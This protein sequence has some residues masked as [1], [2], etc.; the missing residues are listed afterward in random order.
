[1]YG[2][3][4]GII[5]DETERRITECID[6]HRE[7]L[8]D[9]ARDLM[10]H[11][12][13][14]F[15]EIRTASR[16]SAFFA[17]LGLE[18]E[19]GLARTGVRGRMRNCRPGPC[20]TILG[21]M[22]AIG[23]RSHPLADPVNG[24]AHACGHHAQ[25]AAMAGAALA[26]TD[27][28]VRETLDGRVE[29]L[30]VPAEEYVDADRRK[31]LA[32]EGVGFPAS[33]KSEMIRT[34]VFDDT[35]LCMTTHVHMIPVKEDFL[36]GNPTCNG[37]AA[38]RVTIRGKA[39]HAAIDPLDG[40]NALS[41]AGSALSMMGMMRETFP[42]KDHIRLHNLIRKAGDVINSVPDEAILETKV[43][44]ASLEAI[45]RVQ[46]QVSRAYDGAA[47]AFGGRVF[48]E[49]LQGYMPI[50]YREADLAL[51]EAA[52]LLGRSFRKAAPWDFND[53]CT[54]VG[55]LTH[56]FPV[57]NFTF[58]GFAGKLHGEDFQIVDEEKA[59]L[60]PAKLLALTAY[61]LLRDHAD[62]ARIICGEYKP[63]FDKE[64]YCAYIREN[65]YDK[66]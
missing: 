19:E 62:Q 42:E 30:A 2:K 55:D 1:M 63:V 59:Y 28:K 3:K 21:E 45:E 8:L 44:G 54:D 10:R 36:L 11:P 51:T 35:D 33:G 37:F 53:A 47:Y 39:A 32:A 57:V 15:E 16:V 40:V 26:L 5:M 25:L 24:T 12:E 18:V 38:Q 41:I 43:R 61:R 34:G 14:G 66:I 56:L 20:L 17:G 27:E 49:R 58:G 48:R 31:K 13:P 7:E 29:F 50:R 4:G 22:D 9:F 6:A 46:E 64:G 52:G 65:Y 23:C 60:D